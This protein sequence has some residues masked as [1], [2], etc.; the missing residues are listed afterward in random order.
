MAEKKEMKKGHAIMISVPFQGHINPFVSLALK[1]ASKGITITFV[2]L[3]FIHHKISQAHNSNSNSKYNDKFD[4]FSEARQSGLDIRYTMIGDGLPLDYN[5]DL[6]A[7]DYWLHLFN[8]FEARVEEFVENLVIQSSD[9]VPNML[10]TDTVFAWSANIAKKFKLAYV[11]FWT[12]PALVFS[13]HYHLDLLTQNGHYLCKDN[14]QKLEIDYI[15]G[16][17]PMSTKDLMQALRDAD[18]QTAIT[19]F[20]SF[21]EVKKADFILYNT[22]HELESDT[23]SALDKYQPTYAIGP[24]NFSNINS[25]VSKS[26]KAESDCS[27]W[28][29]SKPPGSV[30]YVSFGSLVQ[31][32]KQVIHEVAHGLLLSGVNFIWVVRVGVTGDFADA[33]VLPPGFEDEI[34]DRG[35]IVPWCDQ[36]TVLSS[37]GVGGFLTHCG[38]NST[39]ESMW[40]GVPMICYPISYDQPTNRKLVV[41]DWKIGISL[42]DGTS[43]DRN[44]VAEK[45]KNFMSEAAASRRMRQEAENVK[46][47]L[48]NALEIDGSSKINF[49]RFINDLEKKLFLQ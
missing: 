10:V 4:M 33:D 31:T 3:Q 46:K 16:V 25:T 11:S 26:L 41:D 20:K 6:N 40:C 35:L 19:L 18:D 42:C 14:Y 5:R 45:I 9:L 7:L 15:P 29:D 22:V 39:I 48:Q 30:L 17:Q 8:N 38:W 37:R 2:H 36:I 47:R 23:L 21:E 12:E 34:T 27:R 49:D 28:L 24:V 1:L 43:V 44:E 32:S 13:L